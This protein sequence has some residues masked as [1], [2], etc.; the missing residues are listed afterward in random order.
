MSKERDFP[1]ETLMA[2]ADG[3]LDDTEREAVEKAI[4][5]DPEIAAR[6]AMFMETRDRVRGAFGRTLSERPPDRLFETVMGAKTNGRAAMGSLDAGVTAPFEKAANENR[7]ASSW[8]PLAL[9]A[10]FAAVAAGLAGYLTGVGR[11]GPASALAVVAAAPLEVNSLLSTTD[12]GK[13]ISFS[14][15][16]A[17]G[18]VTGTYRLRDGR[19]CR[20]FEVRHTASNTGV[21]AVGCRDGDRWSLQAAL[22]RTLAD[23]VFRP[24]SAGATVD[25][26]LDAGGAGQALPKL[27]VEGLGRSG[28]R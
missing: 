10:S 2:F 18:S 27:E 13:L 3:E 9:A 11:S 17:G 4:D 8:R 24:A 15:Y 28:W 14:N 1:D 5:A 22:P 21:E 6:V 19:V 20:T 16:P 23:G 25:A 12:E 7:A 26:F